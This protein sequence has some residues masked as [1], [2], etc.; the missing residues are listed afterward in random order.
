MGY[1]NI[2]TTVMDATVLDEKSIEAADVVMADLPCSGLGVMGKKNDIKYNVSL[3]QIK[4]LVKLQRQILQKELGCLME[5][6]VSEP[7]AYEHS[8]AATAAQE[9]PEEPPGTCSVLNGFFVTP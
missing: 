5:P 1:K 6:P 2:K 8:S 4:E 9:P 7:K 3:A